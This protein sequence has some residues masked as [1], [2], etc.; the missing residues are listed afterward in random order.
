MTEIGSVAG[1]LLAAGASTRMG[2]D[3]LWA[4]LGGKPLITWPL[5]ALARSH[6]VDTLVVAATAATYERM[7]CLAAELEFPVRV[8]VGGARR[9]GAAYTGP[10]QGCDQADQ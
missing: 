5:Q 10:R 4:D 3:K 7:L 9:Q 6:L 2:T 1:I 8:V